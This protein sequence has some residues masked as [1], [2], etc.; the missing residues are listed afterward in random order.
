[1]EH[2]IWSNFEDDDD[3]DTLECEKENLN[4]DV[5]AEIIIL[6]KLGLWYGTVNAWRTISKTNIADCFDTAQGDMCEFYVDDLGDLRCKDVHH[7]GTNHYLYR[8]WKPGISESVKFGFLCKWQRGEATR[9]DVTRY[10]KRIGN[11]IADVYGWQV[12]K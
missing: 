3:A 4:I 7:D 10:T 6:A 5:G 12:R 8:M 11:Y 1:M 2:M 9:A